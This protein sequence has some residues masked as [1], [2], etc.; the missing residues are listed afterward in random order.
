MMELRLF[1][2]FVA[3]HSIYWLDIGHHHLFNSL[4]SLEPVIFN[5]VSNPSTQWTEFGAIKSKIILA[6]LYSNLIIIIIPKLFHSQNQMCCWFGRLIYIT[7]KGLLKASLTTSQVAKYWNEITFVI[8]RQVETLSLL[9]SI[10]YSKIIKILWIVSVS[11]NWND[12]GE[13]TAP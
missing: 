11:W 1:K 4:S 12:D 5:C 6:V 8:R 7:V 3:C 10:K 9:E 13:V 2:P